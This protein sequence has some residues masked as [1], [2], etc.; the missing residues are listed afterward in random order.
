MTNHS[1][2]EPPEDV[3]ALL[4]RWS[5]GDSDALDALMPI[6][7]AECRRIAARQLALERR[8]HSLDPTA[9]VHELYLRLVDQRRASWENRA[10]FFG[11]AAR[12][13]RRVLV[14]HARAR[15]AEKRGGDAVFVSLDA[16]ADTPDDSHVADVLAIDEALERL[17]AHDPEQVQ[18]VELR[19]FAGLT[20]EETARVVGRSSRTVK[21][22]WRLAKAWLYQELRGGGS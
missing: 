3:T 20:V 19:Y 1:A 9:L 12:L 18:I 6:I 22:E 10:Q 14:D 11:V 2:D 21:R 17:A 16:A 15:H 5:R 13:M 4:A 7:Y 8:D